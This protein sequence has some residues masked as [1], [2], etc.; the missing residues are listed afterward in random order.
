MSIVDVS[1]SIQDSVMVYNSTWWTSV[2]EAAIVL[3]LQN[4]R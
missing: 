4:Q 2:N 1:K 3:L